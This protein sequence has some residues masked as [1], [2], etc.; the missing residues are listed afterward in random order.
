MRAV[1]WKPTWADEEGGQQAGAVVYVAI[2]CEL[3]LVWETLYENGGGRA[4]AYEAVVC[5]PSLYV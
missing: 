1:A 4:A 5:A 3:R 2:V